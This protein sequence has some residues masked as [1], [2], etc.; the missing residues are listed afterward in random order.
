M[1]CTTG[2]IYNTTMVDEAP[3]AWA[4]LWDEQYAGS[5]LMF[6]NS[7]DAYGHSGLQRGQERQPAHHR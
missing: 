1:L 5:I 6:N 2:I 3:S 7:R 4:D